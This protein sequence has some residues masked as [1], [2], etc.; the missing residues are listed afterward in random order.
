VL[1]GYDWPGNVRE[2]ENHLARALI[3]SRGS[4][5]ELPELPVSGRTLA[6]RGTAGKG[7]VPRF[8]DGVRA[9]VRRALEATGG[10]VYGAEGAAALLGLRPTTLQGKMRKLGVRRG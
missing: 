10:R 3:L 9:L 6:A 2:L 5:L 7:A 8:D 1:E 4:E